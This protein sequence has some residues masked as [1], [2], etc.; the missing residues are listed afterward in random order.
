MNKM[1]QAIINQLNKTDE[2]MTASQLEAH[3]DFRRMDINNRIR[4]TP[5]LFTKHSR[6][7]NKKSGQLAWAYRL[8]D[9][10]VREKI[11]Y[12]SILGFFYLVTKNREL[13]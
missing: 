5:S 2:P 8:K 12:P 11:S 6:I 1:D 13:A 10:P 7:R 4:H 9:D 3:I